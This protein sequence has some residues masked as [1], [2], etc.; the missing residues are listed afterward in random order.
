MAW[1]G[2]HSLGVTAACCGSDHV[3]HECAAGFD[4][5]LKCLAKIED[6]SC[7]L[8]CRTQMACCA[9]KHYVHYPG[10]AP[11]KT[12][13]LQGVQVP[14]VK[15]IAIRTASSHGGDSVSCHRKR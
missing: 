6:K 1:E 2:G 14:Y 13:A 8:K 9:I 3:I 7:G 4:Q 5:A 12:G 10:E 11:M 15:G